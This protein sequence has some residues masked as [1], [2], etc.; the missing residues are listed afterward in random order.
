MKEV[1][2]DPQ[3]LAVAAE[4]S[5]EERPK[6]PWTPSYSVTIHG[7]SLRADPKPEDTTDTQ[8]LE[9]LSTETPSSIVVEPTILEGTSTQAAEDAIEDKLPQPEDL[10]AKGEITVAPADP[11]EL[12]AIESDVQSSSEVKESEQDVVS[13][14]HLFI[15]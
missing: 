14:F 11:D 4:D 8:D 10:Q 1:K 13:G 9:K 5:P 12:A 6:S 15:P 2:T 3:A 7:S